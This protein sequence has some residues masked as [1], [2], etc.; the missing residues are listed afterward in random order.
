MEC[1]KFERKEQ[2]MKKRR[3][4]IPAIVLIIGL[5]IGM[6]P[7]SLIWARI[8]NGGEM[9]NAYE[10]AVMNEGTE[11]SYTVYS[12]RCGSDKDLET[13]R[14][15][16]Y[17]IDDSFLTNLKKNRMFSQTNTKKQKRCT[18][19]GD[20]CDARWFGYRG[21]AGP[22]TYRESE[23]K[24][25]PL[26]EGHFPAGVTIQIN[27]VVSS[28]AH[29]EDG[30]VR[31]KLSAPTGVSSVMT[32]GVCAQMQE[33]AFDKKGALL[34]DASAVCRSVK[35]DNAAYKKIPN[36]KKYT[37]AVD[38]SLN[39]YTG[40]DFTFRAQGSELG[41]GYSTRVYA[42]LTY[43]IQVEGDYRFE[44]AGYIQHCQHGTN[45]AS[46]TAADIEV[47]YP[48]TYE[49][50]GGS[51][52][53]TDNPDKKAAGADYTIRDCGFMAPENR[54]FAGWNT[55]E[56]GSGTAYAVGGVYNKNEPLTL[57]AQWE[58]INYT[59]S[60]N[61]NGGTGTMDDQTGLTVIIWKNQFTRDGYDFEGWWDEREYPMNT[62]GWE[63]KYKEGGTVILESD[64]VLYAQ[65]KPNYTITY[66]ANG[67]SGSM[68]P[69]TKKKDKDYKIAENGFSPPQKPGII[70][71]FKC[72][73]TQAD[74]K[75]DTYEPEDLYK[76]NAS[77]TLYAQ[78]DEQHI[79]S[80]MRYEVNLYHTETGPY[81]HALNPKPES[82]SIAY[83]KGD[84][85]S[86]PAVSLPGYEFLGWF[87]QPKGGTALTEGETWS[88][89]ENRTVYAHWRNKVPENVKIGDGTTFAAAGHEAE[90]AEWSNTPV[91]LQLTGADDG[92]GIKTL[93]LTDAGDNE[94]YWKSYDEGVFVVNETF[95][96]TEIGLTSYL[97]CVTDAEG[98]AEGRSDT[99]SVC[100][101][102]YTVKYD[103]L[104][105]YGS[106]LSVSVGTFENPKGDIWN[107]DNTFNYDAFVTEISVLVS[108]LNGYT[109]PNVS[110]VKRVYLNVFDYY[111]GD[112]AEEREVPL[113]AGTMYVGTYDLKFNSYTEYPSMER[114]RY[115]LWAEDYAGN[116]AMIH[117]WN[118]KNHTMEASIVRNGHDF[119]FPEGS[120]MNYFYSGMKGKVVVK[121]LGP[122]KQFDIE[123]PELDAAITY[124]RNKGYE[125][126]DV[127]ICAEVTAETEGMTL[128]AEGLI[129]Y[130]YDYKLPTFMRAAGILTQNK[131]IW[132]G[133]KRVKATELDAVCKGKTL[134]ERDNCSPCYY[135]LGDI[136]KTFRTR[137]RS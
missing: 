14:G 54:Q 75:G 118:A 98:A 121:A 45:T 76:I 137:I 50:N 82:F 12:Y 28:C 2:D 49:A 129:L 108:D 130:V 94:M 84:T 26:I 92:D 96:N 38:Y 122:F 17:H 100:T 4:A 63:N 46:V 34:E 135:V 41:S 116:T 44:T 58:P 97:L 120:P 31:V 47:T 72:W 57:Y 87:T 81:V 99:G 15:D 48:V 36:V 30:R 51:G 111:T 74:G 29:S 106:N 40:S 52:T 125:Q 60:Y 16:G 93:Q 127:G 21:S 64:M 89:T 7:D 18:C 35:V 91:V 103:P 62:K 19:G 86:L 104:A 134:H 8:G 119:A 131:E 109:Q 101:N 105:P 42:Q 61:A 107:M 124:D 113:C 132:L 73:N 126:P 33:K 1:V 10:Y 114:I 71:T 27:V 112:K 20:N 102:A 68:E 25:V 59:L 85:I 79:S 117:I 23:V 69:G 56:D 32:A 24:L 123:F 77:M 9:A 3:M 11:F 80:T 115:E 37:D 83:K 67:G 133:E 53:M 13:G 43:T 6:L 78:W 66:D 90:M 39:T 22:D 5:L 110:G 70:S 128:N 95:G 65:W 55:K 136:T 88:G